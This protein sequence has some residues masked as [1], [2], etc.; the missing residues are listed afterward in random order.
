MNG[1][2][3]MQDKVVFIELNILLLSLND[4]EMLFN[5]ELLEQVID[6]VLV[7]PARPLLLFVVLRPV[8]N[9]CFS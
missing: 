7:R 5:L 9:G 3:S 1:L 2:N 6:L 4:W 8:S